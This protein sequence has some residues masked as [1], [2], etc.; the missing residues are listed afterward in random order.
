MHP[1][2]YNYVGSLAEVIIGPARCSHCA[3][4]F[5]IDKYMLEYIPSIHRPII[6]GST[7]VYSLDCGHP[8]IN[9]FPEA[10]IL[11]RLLMSQ[12]LNRNIR[13]SSYQ[14]TFQCAPGVHPAR[15]NF[16]P[17]GIGDMLVD[18]SEGGQ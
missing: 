17:G 9:L 2:N 11:G 7:V 1:E 5:Y 15:Y 12:D 8:R 10:L 3:E 13:H 14:Q 6:Y 4:T 18:F 16:W